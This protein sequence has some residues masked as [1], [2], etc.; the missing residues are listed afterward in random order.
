MNWFRSNDM[1]QYVPQ[2]SQTGDLAIDNP[3]MALFL[4]ADLHRAFDKFQFI[5][6]PKATGVLVTHAVESTIELR[7][8]YHNATL[9]QV[10]AGPQF[11]FARFAWA[12]F[13]FLIGFLQRGQYRLLKLATKQKERWVKV[14][15][16]AE[17]SNNTFGRSKVAGKSK[18]ASPTKR[19]R[20]DADVEDIY[21]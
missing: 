8:L 19:S 15:E 20:Q 21:R 16:C 2:Q 6:V 17:L 18:S 7:N 1:Y 5:F 12:I 9:Q 3:A 4:R 10:G 11:L 13:P 14:D